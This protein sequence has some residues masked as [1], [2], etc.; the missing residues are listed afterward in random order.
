MS[1]RLWITFFIIIKSICKKSYPFNLY[2]LFLRSSSLYESW[3]WVPTIKAEWARLSHP[4]L[5]GVG[6]WP[7]PVNPIRT[8]HWVAKSH[9]SLG[10]FSDNGSDACSV[11][12]MGTWWQ[13]CGRAGGEIG[14]WAAEPGSQALLEPALVVTCCQLPWC[15]AYFSSLHT[16]PLCYSIS[17]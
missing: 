5:D 2:F 9:I 17:F 7:R 15:Q 13:R 6:V 1:K 16:A 14:I 12:A 3:L 11:T 10:K 8:L 4:E